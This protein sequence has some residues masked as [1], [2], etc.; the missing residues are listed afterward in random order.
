[1]A[2]KKVGTVIKEA[3]TAAGLSQEQLARKVTGVSVGDLRKVEAGEADFTQA[4]L[5]ALAKPLGVTQ[6]TLLN[7]PKN[8]A[9]KKTG[10]TTAAKKTS[11]TTAKKTSSTTAKKPATTSAAKKP[12]STAAKTGTTGTAKKTATP[13]TPA[14][15]NSTMK[16]TSTERKLIEYYRAASS[17]AKKAA[18]KVLKG[19]ADSMLDSI[20]GKSGVDSVVSN[21]VTNLLGDLLGGKRETPET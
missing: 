5:K 2:T 19:E 8:L 10:T 13:K 1:M 6:A 17:D 9:A 3:R 15:A 7:A 20:N 12:S 14:N 4:Q 18:T 11:T 21:V 16:V